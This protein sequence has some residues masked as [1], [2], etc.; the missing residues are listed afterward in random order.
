MEAL[1]Q[2]AGKVLMSENA[3]KE[4]W[5][6]PTF[7]AFK[8]MIQKDVDP[9]KMSDDS[10]PKPLTVGERV[11]AGMSKSWVNPTYWSREFVTASHITNNIPAG[12]KCII[13]GKDAKNLYYIN[14]PAKV[15]LIIPPSNSEVKETPIYQAAAKLKW[16][17]PEVD[18]EKFKETTC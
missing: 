17:T 4:G 6:A 14:T 5:Q 13:L 8:K 10:G 16:K 11:Q 15:T 1:L 3:E 9:S 7:D 12:S 2:R 18:M